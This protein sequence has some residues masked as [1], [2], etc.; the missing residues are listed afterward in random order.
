MTLHAGKRALNERVALALDLGNCL[1]GPIVKTGCALAD[2][3]LAKSPS[4]VELSKP[5]RSRTQLILQ[6]ETLRADDGI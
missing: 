1:C 6:T 3:S 4:K 2:L 5:S